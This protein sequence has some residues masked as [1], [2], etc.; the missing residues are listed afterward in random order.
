MLKEDEFD[1]DP[2]GLRTTPPGL[3]RGLRLPG[4]DQDDE[5]LSEI[6]AISKK[7]SRNDHEVRS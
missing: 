1:T 5:Y 4:D 6:N 2:K 7:S 3:S